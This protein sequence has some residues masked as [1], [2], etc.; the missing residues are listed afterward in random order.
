MRLALELLTLVIGAGA[1]VVVLPQVTRPGRRSDAAQDRPRAADLASLE[2]LMAIS[3]SSAANVHL[4]LRPVLREVA[5]A[6]LWRQGIA[7]DR[8]RDAARAALGD[9]LYEL[10]APG[11]PRPADPRGPG[12]SLNQIERLIDRLETL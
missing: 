9:D 3:Q 10:V 12:L 4:R 6:R 2:R 8:D 5:A 11:R 1:M 7:L